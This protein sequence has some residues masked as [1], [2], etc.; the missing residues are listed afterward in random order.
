VVVHARAR[1]DSR[2]QGRYLSITPVYVQRED[3]ARGL[4][5]LLT[6]GARVFALGDYLARR[7]LAAE[8][9]TLAGI[10]AGNAKRSTATPTMERMLQAFK[11][12]DL[13]Q[14][15]VGEQTVLQLTD[16]SPVQS[17]ILD[18]LE[19]NSSLYTDLIGGDEK[20]ADAFLLPQH[21]SSQNEQQLPA[22]EF[23]S[24]TL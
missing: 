1:I 12:I 14:I 20:P 11:G 9:T 8:K 19:L 5:H 7:N 24:Q 2:L 13:V 10:Y 16:L 15:T 4:F 21:A 6:L 23:L 22:G 18:L 17:R 3:H